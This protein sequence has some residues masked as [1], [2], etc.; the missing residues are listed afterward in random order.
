MD[1]TLGHCDGTTGWQ[2]RSGH[3]GDLDPSGVKFVAQGFA[4]KNMVQEVKNEGGIEGAIYF[5][6]KTTPAQRGA[7]MKILGDQMK[8]F[9]RKVRNRVGDQEAASGHGA[10]P[11]RPLSRRQSYCSPVRILVPV[12]PPRDLLPNVAL[13]VLEHLIQSG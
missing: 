8:G 4:G 10:R 6:A 3:R 12:S 9:F 7:V 5:D 13:Q 1:T 11:S 2:I